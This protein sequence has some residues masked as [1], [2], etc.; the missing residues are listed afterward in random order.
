MKIELNDYMTVDEAGE[1]LG[2]NRRAV[3]RAIK[4]ARAAGRE[5]TATIVGR[6][7]VLRAKVEVLRQFYFPYYSEAHQ[8][9][10]KKW[11]A[12]GGR[13]AGITKRKQK[14]ARS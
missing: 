3:Y 13:Q 4:R 10:V 9:M 8:R 7:L 6:V 12:A 2:C 5:V 1:A 11:G 14:K